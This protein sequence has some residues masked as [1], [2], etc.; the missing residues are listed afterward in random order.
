MIVTNPYTESVAEISEAVDLAGIYQQANSRAIQWSSRNVTER[1]TALRAAYDECSGVSEKLASLISE[2]MGKPITQS[3]VELGRAL[4]EWRY[5]LDNAP[6]FL[7]PEPLS[8]G[9]WLYFRPL[10]VVAVI[11]PWNFPFLLPLRGIVPALLAGNAVICKPSELTPRVALEF[12]QIISRYAPLEVAIGGKELGAQVVDLPVSAIAFTG[13]SAVGKWIMGRAATSL[14]RVNL[15]LGGLDPAIVLG[16]A[17]LNKAAREI[18][19]NNA[20]NSGQ[21]CNAIKRVLVHES[22]YEPFVARVC[23]FAATLRYGDPHD[24]TT[25]VGPLASA[26]QR[27]RVQGYL[28]DAVAKGAVAHRVSLSTTR[29]YFFPQT[30]LTSVPSSA[31]LLREEAFGPILPIVPFAT[32]EEAITIANDT[33]YGL[34]ASVWS[35]DIPK[36]ESVAAK[37]V[38]GVVRINA[39]GALAAGIPWSGCKESG[40]GQ[41]KSREGLREFTYI[42]V[43]VAS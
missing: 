12:S 34:S 2:E 28:D 17:D 30:I 26:A 9:A 40:I 1:V 19:R 38:C 42:Q 23:E 39:H 15:E 36:A 41:T 7:E 32:I 25:D 37:L 27:D 5:M 35:E 24:P 11:S 43:V 8:G 6:Q 20:A 10:G 16:D 29:G 4:D 14:K 33:P 13:S 21:A 18:V 31:K 22:I 3:R